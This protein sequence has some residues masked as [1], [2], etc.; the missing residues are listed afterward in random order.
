MVKFIPVNYAIVKRS[1]KM[2][3]SRIF[4][5]SYSL[6][7][8]E[9]HYQYMISRKIEITNFREKWRK[10]LPDFFFMLAK[11]SGRSQKWS[12]F[13]ELFKSKIFYDFYIKSYIFNTYFNGHGLNC[14]VGILLFICRVAMDRTNRCWAQ[15]L[16]IKVALLKFYNPDSIGV[17]KNISQ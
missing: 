3:L 15:F 17:N 12:G 11:N 10:L 13:S 1:S 6:T 5:S 8:N 16:I 2:H 7:D 4:F 9:V 14:N